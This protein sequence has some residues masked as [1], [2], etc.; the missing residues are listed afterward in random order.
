VESGSFVGAA[1]RL[2]VPRPTLRRRLEALETEVGVPLLVRTRSGSTPTEAGRALAARGTELLRDAAALVAAV[3]ES[4]DEPRGEL[5]MVLPVGT[6][7]MFVGQ[8]MTVMRNRYPKVT[9]RL[10]TAD[11]PVAALEDEV[12]VAIAFGTH[13]PGGRWV[14]MEIFTVRQWL[15]AS[16]AYLARAGRPASLEELHGHELLAWVAPREDPGRW[17]LRS[18]GTLD[19]IPALSSPD[20]HLLRQVAA[21]GLGI[22][23]VPDAM[24]PDAGPTL[25]PVLEQE[26]GT[27]RPM[28]V[29]VPAAMEGI[30]RIRALLRELRAMRAAFE[31]RNGGR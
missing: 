13:Q 3:R 31:S 27:E 16:E 6:P 2:G 1:R 24:L 11:D 5:R 9:V 20:I 25:V 21:A 4:G 22:A 8:L 30:P 14:S 17:Q 19:V 12:D 29:V 23:F 7:P 10:R 15:V 26:V 18:G 28:Q